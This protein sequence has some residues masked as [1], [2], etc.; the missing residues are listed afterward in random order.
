MLAMILIATSAGVI[1]ILGSVHLLYTYVGP[2]LLPRKRD[3]LSAMKEDSP[4]ISSETSMWK[5]WI[6]FNASHSMGAI[7]FGLVYGYLALFHSELLFDSW[8]L[9]GVGAAMLT[10][11]LVLAKL[12]WFR[13][14][15]IGIAVALA[16]FAGGIVA[17]AL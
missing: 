13:V 10:G 14:P 2:K 4:V 8:Y 7:L 16:C 11:L 9:L 15:F 12:Y 3:V 17:T 6:G 5:A 1:L